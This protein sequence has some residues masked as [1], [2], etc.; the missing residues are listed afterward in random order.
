MDRLNQ[1]S[2]RSG[3]SH[4]F[5]SA[6]AAETQSHMDVRYAD[7]IVRFAVPGEAKPA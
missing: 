6:T 4:L 2:S 5:F 7:V 3:G 1:N